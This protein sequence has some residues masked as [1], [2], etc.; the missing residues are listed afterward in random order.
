VD[1]KI[2]NASSNLEE[3]RYTLS[4]SLKGLKSLERDLHAVQ[5]SITAHGMMIY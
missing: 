2:A 1:K 3:A 4:T 5:N